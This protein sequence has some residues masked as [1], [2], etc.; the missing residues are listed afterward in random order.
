MPPSENQASA[1]YFQSLRSGSERT[2][3]L[4]AV[5]EGPGPL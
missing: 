2:A 4:F 5:W 1:W 3:R